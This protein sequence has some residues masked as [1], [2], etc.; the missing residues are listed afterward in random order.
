MDG[1]VAGVVGL[2]QMQHI[3]YVTDRHI[4]EQLHANRPNL[5]PIGGRG[6]CCISNQQDPR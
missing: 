5:M 1:T 6:G 4:V 2:M 3:M